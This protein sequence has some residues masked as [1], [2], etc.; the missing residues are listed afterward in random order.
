MMWKKER[1]RERERERT[2]R[3]ETISWREVKKE[4]KEKY[5]YLE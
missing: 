1:E 3:D 5:E 2:E 4:E